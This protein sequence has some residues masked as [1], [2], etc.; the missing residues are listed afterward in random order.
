GKLIIILW[1][2]LPIPQFIKDNTQEKYIYRFINQ[3]HECGLCSGVYIFCALALF[4]GVD[5]IL[6]TFG[7]TVPIVGELL[8]G[9]IT[10]FVVFVFSEGWRS[11]YQQEVMI[12]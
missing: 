10:S 9:A 1:M 2:K 4:F 6:D 5:I 12:I 8:T 11:L 3:L 7:H